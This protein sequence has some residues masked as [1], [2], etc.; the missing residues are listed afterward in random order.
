MEFLDFGIQQLV[1]PILIFI[2]QLEIRKFG[3]GSKKSFIFF[4]AFDAV[5]TNIFQNGRRT[6]TWRAAQRPVMRT[7]SSL[8][9]PST[10][11]SAPSGVAAWWFQKLW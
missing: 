1:T 3:F 11:A 4:Y 8:A 6:I 2:P 7:T 10:P 9:L 5:I